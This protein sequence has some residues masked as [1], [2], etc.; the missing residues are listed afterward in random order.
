MKTESEYRKDIVEVC[1]RMH[2]RGWI[3]STDGNV[4]IR[5]PRNKIMITPTGIHKGFMSE[6]DPIIIDMS[7]KLL[8]GALQPSSETM[9][10]LTCYNE[11]PDIGAVVHAHPTMCVAFSLAGVTLAKCM[12]PEVVFTL[13]SIPT[14]E[15]APPTTDE[16]PASIRKHIKEFD[17]V[18]LERHGS[19]TVGKDIFSA[20]NT[21][22]RMEHVAEITYHARQIGRVEPLS[23]KQVERLQTIGDEQGW[24]RKKI[25]HDNCNNCNACNKFSS[26][27][28]CASFEPENGCASKAN[29]VETGAVTATPDDRLMGIVEEEVLAELGLAKQ[30]C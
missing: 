11:R 17:A 2:A 29:L 7:G 20:Y 4:S 27:R 1:K 9:M 22:E 10:H 6:R 14:A 19:V 25:I 16:V 28:N 5:L 3:S 8:Y 15:Y 30:N 18:I 24:P 23:S 12:L 21:L 13:G 26:E